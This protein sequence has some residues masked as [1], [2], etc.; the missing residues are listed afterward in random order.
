M[1]LP[2]AV[3][4]PKMPRVLSYGGIYV[5]IDLSEADK[6]LYVGK[7]FNFTTRA[8]SH[9]DGFQGKADPQPVHKVPSLMAKFEAGCLAMQILEEV[10][11]TTTDHK[12]SLLERKWWDELKPP[13]G[14][15]PMRTKQEKLELGRKKYHDNREDNLAKSKAYRKA[16]HE[17]I[18]AREAAYRADNRERINAKDRERHHRDKDKRNAAKRKYRRE[19][20]EK[21]AEQQRWAQRKHRAKKKAEKLKKEAEEA[22]RAGVSCSEEERTPEEGNLPPVTV[23]R[24]TI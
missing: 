14:Q 4:I 21:Y 19:N 5:I 11:A 7:S 18:L 12:L 15:C 8:R 17:R 22:R 3:L 9:A 23:T 6:V 20:P 24:V 10:P 13:H 1:S 2:R 16:N